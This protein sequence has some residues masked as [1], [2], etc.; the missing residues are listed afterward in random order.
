MS[1]QPG[2]D[3]RPGGPGAAAVTPPPAPRTSS[4]S[5]EV[6]QHLVDRAA[7][8]NM[9]SLPDSSLS[10]PAILASGHSNSVIGVK[11][12]EVLHRFEIITQPPTARTPL[13]ARNIVGEAAGTFTHRWLMM[14]DDF[15]AS[16]GRE[17]PP[18][19]LN[20]SRTQRFVML[21]GTCTF[22][23]GKDGFHGFGT[24]QTLP[25]AIN[26]QP[27]LLVTAVGTIVEGFGRFRGH[28]EGTYVYCGS[29]TPQHGFTGNVLLRVMDRQETFRTEIALPVLEAGSN[30][31][32]E[33]VYMIFRG[34]AVPEDP[35]TPRLGPDGRPTGLI[36][37]QGIR[38]LDVDF[39]SSG[40][41]GPQSTD[42]VGQFVG[43]ITAHVT[44]NPAAPGGTALDPIPFT[45]YDEFVF[46]DRD[47]K[48][49][50]GFTADSSEGRVFNTQLSGQPG[51]RF[52]GVGRILSSTGA[53]EGIRGLMTDNS[54]VVFSPHVSASVYVLRVHDPHGK[55][56]LGPDRMRTESDWKRE[57]HR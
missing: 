4:L 18:T 41:G 45:S 54:V 32:P 19:P 46:L 44:F 13:R 53:F 2:A 1:T 35:V 48:R 12:H 24:G 20:P 49:I 27:Q 30:P 42:R 34:Q 15:V 33:M 31:E 14:P 3:Q 43:R 37:E 56:R 22:G 21:D 29:L 16:P 5:A 38:L 17:P 6:V 57:G 40:R 10:N 23:D 50:G 9:F 7:H 52:G 28:E 47:G 26:G 8:F 39:K 51:I 25:A 55:F 36:V 11:V